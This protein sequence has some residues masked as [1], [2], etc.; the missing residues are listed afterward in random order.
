M[1]FKEELSKET[2]FT[3][4]SLESLRK[5][6]NKE[7]NIEQALRKPKFHNYEISL[8]IRKDNKYDYHIEDAF[9]RKESAQET[10]RKMEEDSH[11]ILSVPVREINQKN[12]YD[13]KSNI[14]LPP[15]EIASVYVTLENR[16]LDK[17]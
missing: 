14:H 7:C 3:K 12:I 16:L 6:I 1:E 15:G 4:Q 2:E 10:V 13:V 11:Y 9:F 8:L 5:E 17:H